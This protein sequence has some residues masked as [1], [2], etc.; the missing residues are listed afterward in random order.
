VTAPRI[1]FYLL[2]RT[3]PDGKLRLACRLTRRVL[4]EGHT[5]FVHVPDRETAGRLDDLM[6]TFDQGS[7]VPHALDDD[8]GG[9][10][11]ATIGCRAPSRN[12]PDVLIALGADIGDGISAYERVAELVD[13]TDED[14]QRARKR[15][16]YYKELGCELETHHLDP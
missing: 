6:W 10:A 2:N 15:Y 1:T 13:A 4:A 16:R 9:P 8:Q 12:A 5:A 7:F 11:P 14:R 3:A